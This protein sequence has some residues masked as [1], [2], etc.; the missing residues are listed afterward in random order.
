MTPKTLANDLKRHFSEN[1]AKTTQHIKIWAQKMEFWRFKPKNPFSA[2]SRNRNYL[3]S[4]F[5]PSLLTQNATPP[6]FF[7]FFTSGLF[8][9]VPRS[10]LQ[11][12]MKSF[13]WYRF[14]KNFWGP[15]SKN[16]RGIYADTD[17]EK[18][19]AK[20]NSD[21]QNPLGPDLEWLLQRSKGICI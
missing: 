16:P 18:C 14:L 1:C 2:I 6:R 8:L 5:W 10:V 11:L 7:N 20:Q 15:F 12:K 19:H 4:Q 3:G 21:I 17:I 9:W 13:W